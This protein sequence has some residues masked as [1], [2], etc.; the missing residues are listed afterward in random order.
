MK[1]TKKI[2]KALSIIKEDRQPFGVMLGEG[3]NLKEAFWCPVILVPLSLAFPNST[4]RQNPKHH[5]RNHL[6]NVSNLVNQH[7]QMK[8]AMDT[9]GYYGY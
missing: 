1:K 5:F 2:L 6:T 4:H 9:M 7:P 3:V 8:P